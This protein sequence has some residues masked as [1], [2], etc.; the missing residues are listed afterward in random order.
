MRSGR[1]WAIGAGAVVAAAVATTLVLRLQQTEELS[2][3]TGAV[4]ADD[5][6][7]Q[8][9]RPIDEA[10]VS[11]VAGVSKGTAVS[12]ESGLF[13]LTLDPAISP[14]QAMTITVEHPDYLPFEASGVLASKL[15][16]L[17]MTPREIG[18]TESTAGKPEVVIANVR[19]RYAY[20]ATASLEVASAARTFDIVNTP[21]TPCNNA[22]PC[23]PDGRWK[24]T[25]ETFSLDAG[26][27]REFRNARVSCLAGPCPFTR[28]VSDAFS[29]GGRVIGGSVL[30]WGDTVTYLV[31]AEVSQTTGSDLV[32]HS[33]PVIFDRFMNFTLPPAAQGPS[34]EAEVNGEPIVF[35]LGP[36]L[37]LSWAT[38][39]LDTGVGQA[40]TGRDRARLFRCELKPGYL[41]K[42]ERADSISPGGRS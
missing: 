24:A 29:A 34:I 3:V 27:N 1:A 32:R 26:A 41:F 31:E 18:R 7:L 2:L 33:Y 8:K 10:R 11:A 25:V 16:L 37:R 30:N 5:S 15:L 42:A 28:V 36:Q 21:N 38:C 23:S 13:R 9:Q 19:V 39:R 17:R 4:L 22:P 6:D 12:D 35:P 14:E 20:R 40:D